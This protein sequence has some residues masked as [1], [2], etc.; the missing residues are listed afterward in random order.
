MYYP[1]LFNEEFCNDLFD[2][3]LHL[4]FD[5]GKRVRNEV[6]DKRRCTTDIKE[7]SDRYVLEMELP[8]YKKDEIKVELKKGHLI[9]SAEHTETKNAEEVR[10]EAEAAETTDAKDTAEAAKVE[11][12]QEVSEQKK[13]EAE[14]KP[15][16]LCRERFLGKTERSFYVGNELTKEDIKAS[17]VNGIL[18][19]E[20]PKKVRKPETDS[21]IISII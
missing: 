14:E 7:Y 20:V 10:T 13:Q 8:G 16:Y 18:T 9:I 1:Y 19:L 3:L 12:G 11:A 15:K 5:Y 4:P 17:F 2:E 21:E 6:V